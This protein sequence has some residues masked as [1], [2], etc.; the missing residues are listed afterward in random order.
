MTRIN[1]RA[2]LLRETATVGLISFS[3]DDATASVVTGQDISN[4]REIFF[5][6]NLT[7]R[8]NAGISNLAGFENGISLDLSN[9]LTRLN[10][11]YFEPE[12]LASRSL[13]T[14]QQIGEAFFSIWNFQMLPSAI[15]LTDGTSWGIAPLG[16][17]SMAEAEVSGLVGVAEIV[18]PIITEPIPIPPINIKFPNQSSPVARNGNSDRTSARFLEPANCGCHILS[19]PSITRCLILCGIL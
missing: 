10:L 3:F 17:L 14:V 2:S 4:N 11:A 19:A 5:L 7:L 18:P 9:Q 6:T 1:L 15:F 16:A 12:N 8:I 13:G